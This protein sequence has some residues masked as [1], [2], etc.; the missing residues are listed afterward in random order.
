MHP[1][2]RG[3]AVWL[4]NSMTL[5]V[6][7]Q[8][9]DSLGRFL[10]QP[11]VMSGQPQMLLGYPVVEAMHMPDIAANSFP[12]AFT[13]L[14]RGYL[15]VDRVGMSVLVDPFSNKPNVQYYARKRLGAC[16]NNSRCIKLMKIATT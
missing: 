3:D 16:V 6:L 15:I 4:M 2:Y 13:N 11:S 1:G 9:K 10:V 8:L 5:G 14:K 7:S 12:V